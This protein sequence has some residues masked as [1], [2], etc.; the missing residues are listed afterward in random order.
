MEGEPRRVAGDWTTKR[1]NQIVYGLLTREDEE[2]DSKANDLL[3]KLQS[4]LDEVQP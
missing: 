2:V 4:E 3:D 1:A